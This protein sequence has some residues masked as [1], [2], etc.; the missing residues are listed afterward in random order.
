M[1]LYRPNQVCPPVAV[2]EHQR[3]FTDGSLAMAIH[4]IPNPQIIE[5]SGFEMLHITLRT[6][7]AGA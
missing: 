5:M 2:R 1:A 3:E 7:A 6:L 4:A